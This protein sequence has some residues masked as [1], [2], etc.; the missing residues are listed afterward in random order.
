MPIKNNK[1]TPIKKYTT[2][3]SK[4]TKLLLEDSQEKPKKIQPLRSPVSKL[5]QAKNDLE[6]ESATIDSIIKQ[7]SNKENKKIE[8]AITKAK[9]DVINEE[10]IL[11]TWDFPKDLENIPY[12]DVNCTY[13]ASGYRPIDKTHGLNFNPDWFTETRDN[14]IKTGY[15]CQFVPGTKLYNQFWDKEYRRCRDGMTV[16]GYTITGPHYF[17][18]NYCKVDAIGDT[19]AGTGQ[20]HI[21]PQFRVYQYEFFHYYE[22]C[23]VYGYNCAMLKNRSCGFSQI[24][25]AIAACTFICYSHSTIIIT[26]NLL[27][28][29][30]KTMSKVTD[31]IN[32]QNS[33]RESAFKR[34]MQVKN[35]QLNK[36]ASY[37]TKIDGQYVEVGPMSMIEGIVADDSKKVRGDRA[38]LVIYEEAGSN[39]ILVP[40]VIKGEELITVGGIRRGIAVIGGTG[41]DSKGAEGLRRIYEQPQ[42]F[43][44]LP[45]KHNYTS[46]GTTVLSCFFIPAYKT[47][48]SPKAVDKRGWCNEEIARQ[49]FQE[50]RDTLAKDPEALLTKCAEQCFTAEEAL[51]LEGNNKFNRTLLA[52][53]IAYM[54]THKGLTKTGDDGKEYPMVPPIKRGELKF[55]YKNASLGMN[56]NNIASIDFIPGENGSLHILEPPK[57]DKFLGLYVAGIDAIDIGQSQ[58]SDATKDPSKFCIIIFRRTFGIEP[59]RP[60]AYYLERP[61]DVNKAYQ[62]TLKLLY[63]YNAM[64][65]IEATR[66]SCWNYSKARGFAKYYMFRPK[67]TYMDLNARHSKTIGTPATPSIIDHQNDLIASYIDEF[68]EQI[69]FQELLDQLTRYSLEN[70]TKFDM[71]AAFAMALLADEE[72]KGYIPQKEEQDKSDWQDIGFYTDENGIKRYGVIPKKENKVIYTNLQIEQNNYVRSSDPRRYES[73]Y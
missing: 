53:Q 62:T 26:A 67:A 29:V 25:S 30:I 7:E 61:D 40:S 17:F 70:K 38:D 11:S 2:S 55:T 27:Q 59:P 51:S 50:E 12:F 43:K 69:W 44:V 54:R 39:P 10:Q 18:L 19:K 4:L 24:I 66:L 13:E 42:V 48:N 16:N 45:F 63:W 58:T 15:Y 22:L 23:R 71:V 56:L 64:A 1:I 73:S 35:D 5:A 60:V 47:L 21:F 14:K 31:V 32:F 41:G 37:L 28:Y 9:K 52:N 72:L 20:E 46:D 68:S 6:I 36:R 34:P 33:C 3:K 49:H 57:E 65:N 8:Q